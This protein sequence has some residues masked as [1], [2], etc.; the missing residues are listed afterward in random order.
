MVNGKWKEGRAILRFKMDMKSK[1]MLMHDLIAYRIIHVD[2]LKATKKYF[3][4]PSYDYTHCIND[5]LED[6][7][8]SFCSREF[9][10]RRMSCYWLLDN[11]HV[12]KPVQWEFTRL[13]ISNTILSMRKLS[14]LVDKGIV[15]GWDDPR[16][17]TLRGLRRRGIPPF[18]INEFVSQIGLTFNDSIVDVKKFENILRNSLRDKEIMNVI[19]MP[20]EMEIEDIESVLIDGDDYRIEQIEK[21]HR[22][23]YEQPVHLVNKF[24]VQLTN[25]YGRKL[26]VKKTDKK[27]KIRIHW[28]HI[29]E[30]NVTIKVRELSHLFNSFNP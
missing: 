11:L 5:S 25:I 4:Y 17:F 6:I 19:Y 22:L 24:T 9:L 18:V 8:H 3:V 1:N 21:Y 14:V 30:E 29:S 20:T 13:R 7:T 12:Y 23:T 28:L 10:S 15:S 2:H 27:F 16:L 26:K